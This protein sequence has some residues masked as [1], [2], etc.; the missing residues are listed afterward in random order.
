[1]CNTCV[2]SGWECVESNMCVPL[3]VTRGTLGH[4]VLWCDHKL[5]NEVLQW[6]PGF[7]LNVCPC[8]NVWWLNQGA[9]CIDF[10]SCWCYDRYVGHVDGSLSFF[11]L[12]LLFSSCFIFKVL[13]GTWG[14]ASAE[15]C[16]QWHKRH[17]NETRSIKLWP[18]RDILLQWSVPAENT[19]ETPVSTAHT[20]YIFC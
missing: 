2:L 7:V 1:M 19:T 18:L 11:S 6:F 15:Y 16:D 5:W 20:R 3:L 8:L 4:P 12:S 14:S 13:Q 17:C 9:P 10:D